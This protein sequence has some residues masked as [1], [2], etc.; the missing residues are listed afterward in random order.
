VNAPVRRPRP[1]EQ[2]KQIVVVDTGV[3]GGWPHCR[4]W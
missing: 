1:I 3:V 2:R 4:P